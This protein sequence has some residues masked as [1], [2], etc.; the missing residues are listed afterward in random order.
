MARM[1]TYLIIIVGLMV[2]FNLAGL[3]TSTGII[4]GQF[5]LR[6]P[7][8]IGDF[9]GTAFWVALAVTGL[10]ALVGVGTNISIGV[11]GIRANEISIT[12]IVATT[13]LIFFVTDLISIGQSLKFGGDWTFVTYLG[14][15]IMLPIIFGFAHSIYDWVRGRD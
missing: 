10:L 14:Y 2:L 5:G 1:F 15:L 13:V 3:A 12:A 8:D 6:E 11:F 9:E 4:L 7:D